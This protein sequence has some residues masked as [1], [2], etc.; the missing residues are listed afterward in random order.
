MAVADPKLRCP[1]CRSTSFTA[2]ITQEIVLA[3]ECDGGV[4]TDRLGLAE[5]EQFVRAGC[6]CRDCNHEWRVRN[7]ELLPEGAY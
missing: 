2:Y 3:F 4:M 1:K 5:L 6:V 7:T